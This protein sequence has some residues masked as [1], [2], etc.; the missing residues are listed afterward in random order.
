MALKLHY[1]A[2]RGVVEPVKT[3]AEY[4][5]TKYEVDQLEWGFPKAKWFEMKQAQIKD[6]FHFAN[7][8]YMVDPKNLIHAKTPLSES[9]AMMLYIIQHSGRQ[10]LLTPQTKM[11]ETAQIHSI[12]KDIFFLISRP[13]YDAPDQSKMVE[14]LKANYKNVVNGKL[15]GISEKIDGGNWLFGEK[16]SWLD[17]IFAEMLEKI[18]DQG[19]ELDCVNFKECGGEE[20]FQIYLDRFLALDK[21]REYRLSERFSQ[22]PYNNMTAIWR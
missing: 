21:I 1:W 3:L 2:I 4:T 16:I 20:G 9:D 10:D 17:F 14:I 15:L 22:R 18:I 7:L 8:P 5:G 12:F 13:C 11:V 19:K 6:G